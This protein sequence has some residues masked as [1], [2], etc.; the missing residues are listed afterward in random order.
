M[1]A[2]ALGQ[3]STR[4]A[5]SRT[6]A[7]GRD[8]G[9]ADMGQFDAKPRSAHHRRSD[10]RFSAIRPCLSTGVSLAGSAVVCGLPGISGRRAPIAGEKTDRLL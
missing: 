4:R 2:S 10:D 7:Q 6:M 5:R 3:R 8:N 9:A 1:S